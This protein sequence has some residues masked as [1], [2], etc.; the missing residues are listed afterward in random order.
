[1]Q[2]VCSLLFLQQ[3]DTRLYPELDKSNS[4]LATTFISD[5][6]KLQSPVYAYIFQWF[7]SFAFSHHYLRT[8]FCLV[9]I[10]LHA[11]PISRSIAVFTKGETFHYAAQ[12]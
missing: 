10:V 12:Q 11:T 5:S 9:P 2:P 3:P 7:S 1:M 4:Q 8:H 6:F